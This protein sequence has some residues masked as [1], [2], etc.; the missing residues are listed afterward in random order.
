MMQKFEMSMMGKLAYFLGFQVKQLKDDTFISQ[1]KYTQDLLKRFG[2][3]DAK[4]AKT[5]MGTDEHIDLN[6]G[7]KSVDQKAYRSMIGSLLYIC[8]SRPD[9][10]LSVCMC[11]RFQSDHNECHL[12]VVKRILRYLV[13]T[14]CFGIWYPK[15]STFDLIGYSDSDYAGCKV[16]RKSTSGTC[17]FLGRS[18]VSWSSKKQTSV[19]LSTVEAEYVAAGQCCV[20]L[21]WIRQTLRDFG[22]NMSKV[23]L[24][25]DNESAICLADNP[26]EHNC[27]KHI[28]IWHHFLRDHQQK[29]DIDVYHISTENQLADIFTKPLEEKRFCRLHSELNVL[30]SRNLD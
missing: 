6:K 22:Y 20:Q 19:A 1:T 2:M 16:D 13:F 25:C 5:P 30:D 14:P 7:G 24:L 10:M 3:K 4:P 29:G 12:V 27:T 21:L 26:V 23:P 28:D 8:A 11:A 15:G 9:I 18:L 17:Q